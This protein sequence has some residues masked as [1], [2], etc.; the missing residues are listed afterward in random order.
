MSVAC[1]SEVKPCCQLHPIEEMMTILT[2]GV[3]T[4]MC[5]H[6]DALHKFKALSA[7]NLEEEETFL[8]MLSMFLK[9]ADLSHST[10]P[11]D[12]HLR[13]FK[14]LEEVVSL[15]KS[16]KNVPLLGSS[17]RHAYST[18][19][20]TIRNQWLSSLKTFACACCI[21][22]VW[23]AHGRQAEGSGLQEF[24]QQGDMEKALG[25]KPSSLT[26]RDKSMA[27]TQVHCC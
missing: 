18:I 26:D 10:F 23:Q 14:M 25:L 8:A 2:P 19:L 5:V 13:W 27:P 6:F 16:I 1:D 17:K 3:Q 4:D 9:C 12:E 7:R 20:D 11:W 15:S 24:H 21:L 22:Q